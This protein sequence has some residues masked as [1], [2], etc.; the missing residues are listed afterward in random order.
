MR[1]NIKAFVGL[2]V[3]KDSIAIAYASADFS[4]APPI[5]GDD[6]LQRHLADESTFK[7]WQAE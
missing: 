7:A 3:H 6:W 4:R 1:D 5:R 2:D